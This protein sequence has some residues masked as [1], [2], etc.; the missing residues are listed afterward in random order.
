ML[1]QICGK[2]RLV[3]TH[4]DSTISTELV[5]VLGLPNNN[6]RNKFMP[7]YEQVRQCPN[8]RHFS[9]PKWKKYVNHHS[10]KRNLYQ[11][12]DYKKSSLYKRM[13]SVSNLIIKEDGTLKNLF[14]FDGH[15]RAT[16]DL[17]DVLKINN[18]PWKKI[19]KKITV[20][21]IDKTVH[22]W[23]TKFLP[24]GINVVHSDIFDKQ[25]LDSQGYIINDNDIV[26][27]NF[28][29]LGSDVVLHDTIYE[30][31]ISRPPKT[32]MISFA[33]CRVE[34]D[35]RKVIN[36]MNKIKLKRCMEPIKLEIKCQGRFEFHTYL[37]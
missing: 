23:H 33:K 4:V 9:I 13:E 15:G 19:N 7:T 37:I 35:A 14:M 36:F 2:T 16:N 31:I 18:I 12:S 17:T 34:V 22:D 26:Y 11:C 10:I 5:K 29:S 27:L 25:K 30:F 8:I 1:S 20:V 21:E 3:R 6:K 32:T 24:N 28:C